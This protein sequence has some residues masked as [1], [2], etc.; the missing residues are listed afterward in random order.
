MYF[1]D[2]EYTAQDFRKESNLFTQF[3][4]D[5]V[6]TAPG[7]SWCTEYYYRHLPDGR[8]RFVMIDSVDN[9]LYANEIFDNSEEF[10]KYVKD[11]TATRDLEP[12][13][14]DEI[15]SLCPED[16][17]QNEEE[18]ELDFNEITAALLH[19]ALIEGDRPLV[20]ALL[21]DFNE[22]RESLY[23]SPY[24]P[25]ISV[26]ELERKKNLYREYYRSKD[27]YVEEQPDKFVCRWPRMVRTVVIG[28][29]SIGYSIASPVGGSHSSTL[30]EDAKDPNDA[31]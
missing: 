5:E 27:G 20:K 24:I 11:Y 18:L 17:R 26:K 25:G 15:L 13:L 3:F 16:I 14:D 6:H 8:Y 29:Y 4:Y 2:T 21:P 19:D 31:R 23:P 28:K 1:T 12:Y 9:E 7:L 22:F 30:F 10:G